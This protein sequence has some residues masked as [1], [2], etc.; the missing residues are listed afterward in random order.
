MIR[1]NYLPFAK[2]HI[3]EDEIHAVTEVIKSGWWTTGPKVEEFE[4]MLSQYL[5]DKNQD[6]IYA[7]ALNSCT[8]A[9]FLSLLALNI[10]AEDEVIVPTWTFTATA[11]VVEWIGAKVILC[12]IEEG[13]LNIDINKAERLITTKTK[14]IIPVHMAGYPYD[15]DSMSSLA[16]K[17]NL[18][19]V[20]DAAHAIGTKYYEKKI[21]HFSDTTCFSFYATKNLAMGEGGAVVSSNKK[22][23]EKLRKIAYFGINK[24]AFK[25]YDAGGTW[26]YDVENLGY[27]CNL[28]SLNA[29]LGLVQLKKLDSMIQR[30]REIASIYKSKLDKRIAFTKD[31]NSHYHTYHLFMIRVPEEIISRDNLSLELKKRNIGTSVHFIPLHL[32]SYYKN[33][34]CNSNFDIAN[35]VYQNILSLPLYPSM[36]NEDID[37]VI[38][39]VNDILS[40]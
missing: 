32:H 13:S 10:T 26:K 23:I 20:E 4:F 3:T 28:D 11:H 33:R 27:K 35:K 14:A 37:Y 5:Q 7:I 36:T 24:D 31:D 29:A 19:V 21:G 17:Y 8:S 34:F 16:D 6:A 30:R 2:P 25:R 38:Y 9:L 39:H 22:T 1:K 40:H 18:K 12:D 15:I